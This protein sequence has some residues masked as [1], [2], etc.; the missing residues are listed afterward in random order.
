MSRYLCHLNTG[1]CRSL[2]QPLKLASPTLV[3]MCIN[4]LLVV[5]RD[6]VQCPVQ[7]TVMVRRISSAVQ[8]GGLPVIPNR[9][10]LAQ[11]KDTVCRDGAQKTIIEGIAVL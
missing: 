8:G 9:S 4:P 5:V 6:Q 3:Y 10:V 7:P 11:I 1:N 2:G